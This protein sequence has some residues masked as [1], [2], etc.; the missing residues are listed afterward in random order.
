MATAE[1]RV[2]VARNIARKCVEVALVLR[3]LSHPVR[4]KIL[5]RLVERER[6]V[7]ELTDACGTSQSAMSQFLKR[8]KN[9]GLVDSRRESHF[10][11]YRIAD[12]KLHELMRAMSDIYC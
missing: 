10:I 4:L 3:S 5:S 2:D 12:P 6:S 9:E 8:M 7:N 11:Y 1:A